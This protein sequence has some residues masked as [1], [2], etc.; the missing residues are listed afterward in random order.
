[1]GNTATGN[2]PGM[3][4]TTFMV[5]FRRLPNGN[6]DHTSSMQLQALYTDLTH[7]AELID[8]VEQNCNPEEPYSLTAIIQMQ[9]DA[10][11]I[12]SRVYGIML[13]GA[14]NE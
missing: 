14:N 13:T 4:N 11:R 5:V 8:F 7:W 10:G 6:N 9:L 1:M 12:G 2:L 3:Q